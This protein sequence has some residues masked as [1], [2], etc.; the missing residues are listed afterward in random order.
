MLLAV[1]ALLYLG[2]LWGPALLVARRLQRERALPM[3][4]WLRAIL[5]GQLVLTV[6]L[7][8]LA[9]ALGLRNPAGLLALVTVG[10]SALGALLMLLRTC[11][12]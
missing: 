7:L 1:L 10:V 9:D 3:L 12:K 11:V 2:L 4:G 6:L 5:P 8:V